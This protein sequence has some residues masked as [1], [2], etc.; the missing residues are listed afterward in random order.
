MSGPAD[1][2]LPAGDR[3]LVIVSNRGPLTVE[4]GPDGELE[5]RR[6]AGGLVSGLTPLV[7]GTDTLWIAAAM[8]DGERQAASDGVL[9]A[10][11]FH[12]LS[13][14]LDPHEYRMA[15]DVVCNA[16]LWFLHHHL[17]DLARRPRFDSTWRRAWMAYRSVN[18]AF[19]EAVV[20]HAPRDATV[21]VQDY[22]LTLL[23]PMVKAARRDLRLVHFSHTPFA[24]P[25]QFAVLPDDVATVMLE[26]LAAHDA[27]GF[28]T[29]RW[30][31]A[32]EAA[33]EDR[34]GVTPHTFVA[35]LAPDRDD[36]RAVAASAAC[37][38]ERLGIE[39]ELAGRQFIARVDRIELSKNLLRGFHAFDDL[40]E[41]YPEHRDRVV[42]GAFVYRSREGL[43]EYLAY[44]Q[45][46][47]NLVARINARWSTPDWTPILLD[48]SD[49]FPRSIAALRQYD[50]LLVNPIRDGLNLVAKE[51]PIV[52]ER[53]G[54]LLLSPE[55][56]A[57]AELAEAAIRVNPFDISGTADALHDALLLAPPAR[58]EHAAMV[59]A[60]ALA[61]TP[62][63][64]LRDQIQAAGR[65]HPA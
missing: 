63:D 24:S 21:L 65:A 53:D 30:A 1:S 2:L 17:Y 16:T 4:L 64:W 46:V 8:T 13:L 50:V 48:T 23:A 28:H 37:E 49:N 38:E 47:E 7:A 26:A 44:A 12:L 9:D 51:G 10:E 22:H 20:D 55:A 25:D 6:G 5:V 56:G 15:Y 33:C 61:R 42:F 39:T 3:P 52:N 43:A 19:A 58:A 29:Q 34:I 57:W 41:R 36:I 32:F 27:V 40:L 35:P 11:G 18:L 60:R 31:H 54:V 45:E 62:A 59:R 14:V